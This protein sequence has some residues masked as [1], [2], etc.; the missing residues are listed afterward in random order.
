MQFNVFKLTKEEIMPGLNGKGPRNEGSMTGRGLGNCR[1]ADNRA[2]DSNFND[3][4]RKIN[5]DD[6]KQEAAN[7]PD[8]VVYGRGRGG[9]PYGGGGQG[10]GRGQGSG[11]GRG[12]RNGG[13]QGFQQ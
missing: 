5:P 13:G 12:R 6:L 7:N 1:P 3:Q 8:P 10:L 2:N 4:L 9:I 11:R